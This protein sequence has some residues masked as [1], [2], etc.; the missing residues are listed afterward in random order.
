[1]DYRI[2]IGLGAG[3]LLV[4]LVVYLISNSFELTHTYDSI[5][6]FLSGLGVGSGIALTWSGWS[7]RKRG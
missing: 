2:K 3:L 4:G 5:L 7:G 1:M 6:S